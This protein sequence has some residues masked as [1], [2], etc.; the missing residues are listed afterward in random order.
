MAQPGPV[1]TASVRPDLPSQSMSSTTGVC[2]AC[3]GGGVV[4]PSLVEMTWTSKQYWIS[5]Q[6]GVCLLTGDWDSEW[7][8]VL[9]DASV[10]LVPWKPFDGVGV[11][12]S[13]WTITPDFWLSRSLDWVAINTELSTI[14]WNYWICSF[15]S[16]TKAYVRK[17]RNNRLMLGTSN[18]QWVRNLFNHQQ[19]TPLWAW[20]ALLTWGQVPTS[21]IKPPD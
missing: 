5:V 10:S 12:P 11:L 17:W 13:V 20:K 1:T 15:S 21:L 14:H 3:G 6:S 4:P 7:H 8:G 9:P 16:G 18:S 2:Q 19:W